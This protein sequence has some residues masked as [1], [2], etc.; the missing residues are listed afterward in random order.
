MSGIACSVSEAAPPDWDGYVRAHPESGIFHLAPAVSIGAR[1][2]GLRTHFVTAR[3][4]GGR[5]V[6]VLPLVE[7]MLIPRTRTLVSLPFCTYGGPLA[8]DQAAFEALVSTVG[9]LAE[10]RRAR[11]IVLRLSRATAAAGYAESLDKVAMVLELPGSRN[12]LSKRLGSKLR[13]QVRRAERANPEVRIGRHELLDDFYNVF[14]SVMRDLGTPVYPRRFFDAVVDAL[15]DAAAVVVIRVDG[16]AVAGAVTTNWHG[17]ME[18]PWAGTLH[19]MNPLSINM[20]LYWELL[21]L[22]IER[23]CHRFDFG[24]SSRDSGTQRFKAQW[25]AQPVQLHWLTH[26]RSGDGSAEA[27]ARGPSLFDAASRTWSRLPLWLT[28][29]LGPGISPRLPW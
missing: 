2:F 7:Q 18:V 16:R 27:P 11:R 8:E 9:R 22:A 19:A 6:G 20:R 4:S 23:G 29:A 13:S 25:G 5:L 24:R 1:V 14:C 28:N 15:G 10:Q 21:G 12:E 26:D 3:D 17:V